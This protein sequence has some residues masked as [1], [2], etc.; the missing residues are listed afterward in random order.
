MKTKLIWLLD[1]MFEDEASRPSAEEIAWRAA[2]VRTAKAIGYALCAAWAI[3]ES[4]RYAARHST[5]MFETTGTVLWMG[6]ASFDNSVPGTNGHA[7]LV[8]RVWQDGV[9]LQLD[10]LPEPVLY[11][12][13]PTTGDLR[14]LMVGDRVHVQYRRG[15]WLFWEEMSVTRVSKMDGPPAARRP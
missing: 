8:R 15:S 7:T 2:C 13:S 11:T 1:W 5:H 9:R 6:D 4:G 3:Y 14:S 10:G 12:D